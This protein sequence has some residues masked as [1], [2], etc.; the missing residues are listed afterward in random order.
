[1]KLLNIIQKFTLVF[2]LLIGFT[3]FSQNIIKATDLNSEWTLVKDQDGIKMYVST[4][5]CKVGPLKKPLEYVFIKIENQNSESKD[6]YFQLGIHY[7]EGCEGCEE[8]N[9]SQRAITLEANSTIECDCTFENGNLSYLII[10]PNYTDTKVF[11]GIEL[12]NFKI[13]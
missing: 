13:N 1:M 2:T 9:E 11:E 6:L 3:S 7:D 10:N 5:G 12:I 4:E 8:H